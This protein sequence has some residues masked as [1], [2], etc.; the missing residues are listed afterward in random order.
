MKLE[1][2]F[3]ETIRAIKFHILYRKYSGHETYIYYVA[4][5][6]IAVLWRTVHIY[7]YIHICIYTH[8]CIL[9]IY[10]INIQPLGYFGQEP[11][12]IQATGMALVRWI[13]GKF[14]GVVC[15]CFPPRL[16]LPTF[17]GTMVE[18]RL[19]GN[20]AY[21]ASLCTSL[22]MFYMPQI[23]DMWPTALLPLRWK[24]CWGFFRP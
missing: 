15:H 3:A 22:G 11:E 9:Y 21:M 23:Y 19:S 16:D 13:L 1:T 5:Q 14:L 17:Y 7:I 8:I 20:F 12:P 10:I 24:A 2:L 4:F 18:K 6:P